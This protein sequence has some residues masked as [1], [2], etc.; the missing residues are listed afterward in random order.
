MLLTSNWSVI[1]EPTFRERTSVLLN[2]DP[3]AEFRI[4]LHVRWWQFWRWHEIFSEDYILSRADAI[5]TGRK[6]AKSFAES[7]ARRV[8][9]V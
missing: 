9:D 3:P 5:L 2:L 6:F 4:V 1:D 7:L 8:D